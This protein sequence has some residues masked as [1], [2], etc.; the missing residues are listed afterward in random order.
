MEEKKPTRKKTSGK[1]KKRLPKKPTPEKFKPHNIK[2]A[3]KKATGRPLIFKPEFVEQVYR[4]CLLNKDITE[5]EM[6]D[7]F[8]VD[9]N[10]IALWKSQYKEF[11]DAVTEGKQNADLQVVNGMFQNALGFYKKVEKPV[12]TVSG[13]E[14][15]EYMQYYPPNLAAQKFILNSR[16]SKLWTEKTAIEHSGE[17]SIGSSLEEARKRIKD[18]D[19]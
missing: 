19:S 8:F 15:V 7:F 5:A 11:M 13:V 6:A 18:S 16:H 12:S 1:A 10:T 3:Q 17:M 9:T 4:L 14:I 2:S